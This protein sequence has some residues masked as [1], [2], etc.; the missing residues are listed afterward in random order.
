MDNLGS[1][2]EDL[3]SADVLTA[4]TLFFVDGSGEEGAFTKAFD[5]DEDEE[6]V[7]SHAMLGMDD[8]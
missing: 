3:S 5:T 1:H 7:F 4:E 6:D 8:F 2:S